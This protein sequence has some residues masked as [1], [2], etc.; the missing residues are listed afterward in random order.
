MLT[1]HHMSG[2][3]RRN[4]QRPSSQPST[5]IRLPCSSP[6][7]SQTPIRRP[8]QGNLPRLL[9]SRTTPAPC[10]PCAPVADT[11]SETSSTVSNAWDDV[12]L[13]PS[14]R[15]GAVRSGLP[16]VL[17]KEL[18]TDIEAEG[19]IHAANFRLNTIINRKPDVY[20]IEGTKLRRSV[21]NKT[22]K[23]RRISQVQYLTLLNYM[24][25]HANQSSNLFT[26]APLTVSR[27]PVRLQPQRAAY[28][29][30]CDDQ[31]TAVDT[32]PRTQTST[33]RGLQSAARTLAMNQQRWFSDF[34]MTGVCK[35]FV[36]SVVPDSAPFAYHFVL[37]MLLKLI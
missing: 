32:P 31:L 16:D 33:H 4:L 13:A 25:V 5:P 3:S 27:T 10:L 9:S 12:G 24:G 17:I 19:G 28:D 34:D 14:A 37:Q 11:A 30:P 36:I 21:Q 22:D 18:L 1:K 26:S 29:S 2:S 6:S 15:F 20:G 23:L 7:Q 35:L 8:A